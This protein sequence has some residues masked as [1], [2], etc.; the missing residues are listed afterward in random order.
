MN[1][2]LIAPMYLLLF[3]LMVSLALAATKPI[4]GYVVLSNG[5]AAENATVTVYVNTSFSSVNPCYTL[6]SVLTGSD[7]SYSTNL[8]NLK[9][10][11]NN[12]DCSGLWATGDPIWAFANGSTV[13]PAAQG[14]NNSPITTISSGTGLQILSN[15][16]LPPLD[17]T[18]PLIILIS[19]A[20]SNWSRTG[21]VIFQY[22]VSDASAITSCSLIFNGT[23]NETDDTITKDITQEFTK[24]DLPD[25]IY[26]WS[27]NCTDSQNN[28]NTSEFRLLNVTKTGYLGSILITPSSDVSVNKGD[29]FEF[30]T[31]VSCFGWACGDVNAS[32]D[33][34]E[35][36][37]KKEDTRSFLQKVLDYF[38]RMDSII[39]AFAVGNLVPTTPSTPFWTSS[40]N[41]ADLNDFACLGN[42][43]AGSS[44]NV[45]WMVNASGNIS[46][47]RE[48]FA[49]FNSTTYPDISNETARINI[50]IGD[51]TP[52]EVTA[53]LAIP[54]EINQTQ[55][56]NITA[57][58]TDASMDMVRVQIT[59]P[60]TSSQIFQM[61]PG[62][63]DGWYYGFTP[64]LA[65]PKGTYTAR[66]LANDT[67]NNLNDTETADFN[68]YDV[69]P[70]F[71]SNNKTYPASPSTYSS[72]GNYQFNITWQDN[73]D[74]DKVLIEHNF[75]GTLQNHTISTREGDEYYYDHAGLAAGS[76]SWKEYANDTSNNWNQTPLWIY[77]VNQAAPSCSL[78]FDKTSPQ[79]YGTQINASC[80]CTNP[81]TTAALYRE[82]VDVTSTENNQLISLSA[83]VHNYTCNSS[84]TQNYTSAADS[85]SFTVNPAATV[86]TLT[87]SPSWTETYGTITTVN[88]TANNDEVSPQLYQNGSLVSNGHSALL[89]KGSYNYTCNASASQNYTSAENSNLLT[90]NK[91]SSSCSLLFDPP[92]YATYP[93][94][95]N[96]SCSCT[97]PEAA[98]VLYRDNVDVTGTENNQY[99]L[100]AA[101]AYSYNC[102]VQATQNYTYA[103][104]FSTYVVNKNVTQISL[105][106]N[107]QDAGIN[108]DDN[109]TVN[110]S[111]SLSPIDGF[112]YL[113]ED[114][115]LLFNG[116][117]PF[118]FSKHYN[119]TR[120]YTIKANYSGNENYTS[121][122]RS[123]ALMVGVAPEPVSSR[124]GSK[125]IRAC[126]DGRDN[127]GDGLIDREDPGCYVDY[128]LSKEYL[129]WHDSEWNPEC[130]RDLC[131]GTLLNRCINNNYERENNAPKWRSV[132]S[133][134]G[135]G[136]I[137]I[138]GEL[139]REEIKP[140]EFVPAPQPVPEIAAP[141]YIPV[142]AK[143]A[144][145]NLWQKIRQYALPGAL[146]SA[147][148]FLTIGGAFAYSSL[149]APRLLLGKAA[150]LQGYI[151][152]S[153][154]AGNTPPQIKV[155]LLKKGWPEKVA[156]EYIRSALPT[157]TEAPAALHPAAEI[158]SSPQQ[159]LAAGKMM[160]LE[161][162]IK[163]SLNSGKEIT[164]LR[165]ELI[166][167]GW[168]AKFIEEILSR[169]GR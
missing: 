34:I 151:Q 78:T 101:K 122:S 165:G 130:D 60:D 40:S 74:V 39:T 100:L 72:G 119:E 138:S 33:P 140:V 63:G 167:K 97:N 145:V 79:T 12:M 3:L 9:R 57:N 125:G 103:E 64:G 56:T 16:S 127:D 96:A 53:V 102:S 91:A 1:Q 134:Y 20:D 71:W 164:Q 128:D 47:K 110:F 49:Y 35:A 131:Q 118:N 142:P 136:W 61:N 144:Q 116:T 146:I 69:T 21:N 147:V 88:C 129:P 114:D 155:E 17:N 152:S 80:S 46:E 169:L 66:I 37:E 104:N 45:T 113:Y 73:L 153:L 162:F 26:N 43:Q 68:V 51:S 154:S 27:V 117:T 8:G 25:G 30:K 11:D 41:P 92:T 158:A 59:F 159:Y 50:T 115:I 163:S 94:Q 19:P 86:L 139:R 48:F 15:T 107:G 58:V 62:S 84:A 99:A 29:L 106:L 126:N 95:V 24:T 22:N 89:A 135:Q 28:E 42:M 67:S 7:G 38:R 2:K 150:E 4:A 13:I 120:A 112:A 32:L 105:L 93:Q 70:P 137:C 77:L 85:A 98:F 82:N 160:E 108:V 109:T 6:P 156:D 132:E 36:P 166:S 55:T 168:P 111:V 124:G 54:S 83:A 149:I 65:D 18:P 44:C 10:A 121:A 31:E 14:N 123:H 81:E 143:P 157:G 161:Q 141:A 52:P 133:I 148:I 75:S 87:S 23:I 90:I 76:Y 5:S